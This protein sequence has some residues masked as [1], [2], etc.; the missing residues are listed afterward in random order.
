ML[1]TMKRWCV[2]AFCSGLW[3]IP[4]PVDQILDSHIVW[5]HEQWWL[6]E[7]NPGKKSGHILHLLCHQGPLGTVCLQQN[8]DHVWPWSGYHLYHNTAK[9]GYSGVVRES[10]GEWNGTLLSSVMR[11]GSAYIRVMDIHMYGIDVVSVIFQSA[12]TPETQA[13]PQASWSGGPSVTTSW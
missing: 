6:P 7:Q 9:H 8:S 2:A 12:I 5:T 3:D 10:I 13:L 4:T 1:S 11:V